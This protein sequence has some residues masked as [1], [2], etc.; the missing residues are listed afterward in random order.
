MLRHAATRAF[1]SS[2]ARASA[3]AEFALPKDVPTH[4]PAPVATVANADSGLRVGAFDHHGPFAS[5]VLVVPAGARAESSETLGAAQYLKNYALKYTAT[6]TPLKIAREVELRGVTINTSVEREHLVYQAEFL[7]DDLQFVVSL[8]ADVVYNT[9]YNPWEFKDVA[10]LTAAQTAAAAGNV[11]DVAFEAAH[12]LAFR[13]GLGNSLIAPVYSNISNDT[14]KAFAKDHL[15]IN[16]QAALYGVGV[17]GD[18]L[19]SLANAY[20][21][22]SAAA[23][24]ATPAAK[25]FGGESRIDVAKGNNV[26]VAFNGAAANTQDAAAL[27]VLAAYLG[28][29]KHVKWGNAVSPLAKAG[30]DAHALVRAFNATYSDAGLFGLSATCKTSPQNATK[31]RTDLYRVPLWTLPLN[32]VAVPGVFS[33]GPELRL[34]A[35]VTYGSDEQLDVTTGFDL[36][37]PLK[38]TMASD[39]GLFGKP[40]FTSSF[41]PAF[42]Y[43]PVTASQDFSVRVAAHLIPEFGVTIAILSMTAFSLDFGV[44]NALGVQLSRGKHRN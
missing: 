39:K 19:A 24:A 16:N 26:T 35:A 20:F 3:Y 15:L 28:G 41:E 34:I 13:Q 11:T 9:Q 23:K 12:R 32:P 18:E 25:Y 8:L 38:W 21:A 7:R 30:Q 27:S 5:L 1:S 4:A 43:H 40:K 22:Q 33:L 31:A 29:V 17:N 14:V 6:Q 2:A 36:D 44:D 37:L 10:T 42:N